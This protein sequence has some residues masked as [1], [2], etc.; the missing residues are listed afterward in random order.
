MRN[1]LIFISV[2]GEKKYKETVQPYLDK[3]NGKGWENRMEK[4]V[5]NIKKTP[6]K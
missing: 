5:E 4:E 3:R 6:L 2:K 1:K